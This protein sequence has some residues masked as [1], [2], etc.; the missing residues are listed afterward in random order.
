MCGV[1]G[2]YNLDG[3]PVQEADLRKMADA[4]SHRGPDGDGFWIGGHVG[5]GHRR[6]AI[7]DLSEAGEQPMLDPEERAVV[8]YNGEIYNDAALRDLLQRQAGWRFRGHCDTEVVAP[9][10]LTFG[11][12]CLR[13]FEG[14]FAFALYE[15]AADRLV[16]ARDRTG[17]K[18]LY[19]AL[20]GRTLRFA[21]EIKS[22]LVFEDQSREIDGDA[23]HGFLALGY[24]GPERTLLQ[25]IKP[26]PPGAFLVVE[27]GALRV[28]T[29]WRPERRPETRSFEETLEAFL[30]LWRST[31]EKTLVSDVPVGLLLSG[32]IDSS[33][34]AAGLPRGAIDTAVTVGFAESSYDETGLARH[35]AQKF[36]LPHSVADLDGGA[37]D[38]EALFR[39]VVRAFDGQLAD[40]SGLAFYQACRRGR[41]F[42]PVL[43]TG[44][45][46]DEFFAGYETY[47]ASRYA[48]RFGRFVPPPVA[49][50]LAA[51]FR[52]LGRS[53]EARLTTWEKLGR[54]FAGLAAGGPDLAHAQWRRYLF[55]DWIEGLYAGEMRRRAE[56]NPLAGYEAA[57]RSGN[58]GLF[59]HCLQADQAY[60]LPG[61]MLVKAD[62]MSM[63]HGLEI[64]VPFL[65]PAI[66]DFAAS[67]SESQLYPAGGPPKR[68]LRAALSRLGGPEEVV[69]GGKKGFNVPVAQLLRGGLRG[70]GD[71]L[72]LREA[73][74][75]SAWFD[76]KALGCLWTAH[77]AREADHGFA[78]WA[79]LTFAAWLEDLE[80]AGPAQ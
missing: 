52:R 78:L 9:S 13:R 74:R 45:G 35:V 63:A 51:T 50:S 2:I 27:K 55:A 66:I 7:R 31:V 36:H 68:L 48:A 49:R 57:L 30:P 12:D 26:L 20:N 80:N 18:P 19:Y 62:I 37:E 53:R 4:I 8:S 10:W 76:P 41:E 65:E 46:A 40:S 16:L 5:L 15:P 58:G 25:Q 28:E 60:Y 70:L 75:L 79:L 23:L 17:I 29:W 56:D 43:L 39:R 47:T 44:D 6:L 34:I 54:F 11:A 42:A 77:Q 32:G 1:V 21:S 14:M 61:D 69:R 38:E 59:D 33:L 24:P 67:L 72:L 64:R 3:A 22:L 73:G 71:R